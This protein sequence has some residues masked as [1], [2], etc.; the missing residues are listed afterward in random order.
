MPLRFRRSS[1]PLL[2][3][4]APLAGCAGTS[5][6]FPSL[7]PRQGEMAREIVAPGEGAVPSLA[8]EQQQ[9]LR[10]D[11]KNERANLDETEAAIGATGSELTRALAA[12]RA[13]QPGAESWSAAQL[14][15]SRFDVARGP[16]GD[17]RA[18]LAP[19]QRTVDSLPSD[20]PDRRMVLDLAARAE[21][22]A[23]TAASKSEAAARA[24]GN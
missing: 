1:L 4:L 22:A 6:S 2:V 24:L 10:A 20:D 18:R 9:G 15:L 23:A 14:A 13:S 21:T 16:L 17:I 3:V 8:P 11:V 5:G 12:A 7:A 19:L